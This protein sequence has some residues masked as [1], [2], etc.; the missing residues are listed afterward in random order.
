M[1]CR[2]F[3]TF[4]NK[5]NQVFSKRLRVVAEN[6]QGRFSS[7]WIFWSNKSDFYFSAKSTSGSLKIS[8][9]KNGRGYVGFHRPYFEKKIAEGINIP[10]KTRFEWELPKP[11]EFGVV[12]AASIL[13]PADYCRSSLSEDASKKTLALG[14][15]DNCTA[16][17]GVFLSYEGKETLEEKF[18]NIGNPIAMVTLDN[19]INV[20]IVVRSG[21]FDP[22]ILPTP[23][24]YSNG[25][26]FL[27]QTASV[28]EEHNL[29]AIMF[30]E[31]KDGEAL[32]VV[33]IGGLSL[34]KKA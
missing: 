17:I 14:I 32:Q 8:L 9:H 34:V 26:M 11:K 16:E 28:I 1:Q 15:E 18:K 4:I 20:S 30:N 29:N 7:T 6:P 10:S 13:L 21:P 19:L 12:H 25:R 5:I 3:M 33:D 24:Q 2:F 31:P 23:E 22:A 27:L